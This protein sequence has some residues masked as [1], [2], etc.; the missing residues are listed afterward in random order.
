MHV[1][2][3]HREARPCSRR[4][5]S[6]TC[7]GT[8]HRSP[9]RGSAATR[10][11]TIRA[12]RRGSGRRTGRTPRRPFQRRPCDDASPR[13]TRRR[14]HLAAREDVSPDEVGIV[15]GFIP[16]VVGHGDQ[17]QTD[18]AAWPRQLLQL[19]EVRVPL[20]L[21]DGFHHLH[22]DDVIEAS[23]GVPEVL[24]ARGHPVRSPRSATSFSTWSNCSLDT[25]IVVTRHPIVPASS[26]ANA[27]PPRTDLQHVVTGADAG[28]VGETSVLLSLRIR[29]RFLAIGEDAQRSRSWSRRATAS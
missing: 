21:R 7:A 17:L 10:R 16:M 6:A 20:R 19:M 2:P 1:H 13:S 12:T 22:R 4:G 5:S 14:G 8:S 3:A 26:T 15:V 9:A 29:D 25:V 18:R 11:R 27:A 23:P 28:R 24:Q